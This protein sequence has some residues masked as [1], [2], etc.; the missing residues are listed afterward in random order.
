MTV[1]DLNLDRI[2]A[3]KI[4]ELTIVTAKQAVLIE[5]MRKELAARDAEIARLKALEPELKLKSTT[6]DAAPENANGKAH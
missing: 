4:G 5:T 3:Q 6:T 2:I 1:P